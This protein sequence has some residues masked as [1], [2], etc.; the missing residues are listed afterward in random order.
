MA[1][2]SRDSGPPTWA[3]TQPMNPLAEPYA[4]TTPGVLNSTAQG[5]H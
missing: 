4:T 2:S 5:Q 1:E 3:D